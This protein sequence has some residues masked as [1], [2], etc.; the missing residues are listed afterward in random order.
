MSGEFETRMQQ[1]EQEAYGLAGREFNIGSPKQ[2]GD[3]LF[4][5]MKLEGGAKTKTGAWSTDASVL[6]ELA[7]EH[8]LP[9]KVLDWRQLSKL[10]ST[11][12]EALGQA[13]NPKTNRV[14][15]S[16]ALASTTTGRLSSNDPNLQNIPIRTE[17]GRRIRDAFIA[18]PG[19]VL[20]SAD[21]SQIEL[22]L[23]AHVADI[24]QLKQAFADGVDIHARTASEMFG[25][26]VEGMP[27]EVRNNAK[28]INFGI[29]YGISAFGLA[30][31][32]GI[33]RDEAG[34][35]IKKYF[36]RFPGI[37]DYMEET[38][39]FAR[40]NGYVKTIFGRR[41]WVAGVKSKNPTERA[42]GERQAINAPLQG[43]AA[44][45]IRRAMVRLPDALKQNRLKGR[46]LLQVHDEL[47]FEA[48]KTEAEALCKLAREVMEA[49]P[50][51]VVNLSV[52]LTVEAKAGASWG[53]AH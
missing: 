13:I 40:A 1:Y 26:P 16:Y 24:P 19:N 25:V 18:E 48:P 46:M 23:L 21:Y 4:G 11:Y 43:A 50:H 32:L 38:K 17:E 2:L 33:G 9:R 20:V 31:N 30:R 5:E 42:F 8:E 47:V 22:R 35:Y 41:V 51:P 44:D 14:H 28:A 10:R 15:T 53:A 52:P 39:T 27:K 12:T 29:I 37:R 34:A 7:L 6:E 49:A 3:I 36:E 45:I